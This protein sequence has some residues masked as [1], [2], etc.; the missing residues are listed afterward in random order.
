[1]SGLE[2]LKWLE[3]S[4]I[5]DNFEVLEFRQRLS[6]FFLKLKVEFIDKSRL[7]TKEYIDE[8][9]NNYS[10]HWQDSESNFIIRW[11]NAPHHKNFST[12]PHHLHEKEENKIEESLVIS[13]LEVLEF[14][15]NKL[16]DFS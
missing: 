5:V 16:K 2:I 4:P 7:F 12:Y 1:M 15:E 3:N 13:L 10:F 9:E 8:I 11:D 14:I 6:V